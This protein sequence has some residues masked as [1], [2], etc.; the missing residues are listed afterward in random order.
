MDGL[1][2]WTLV[3]LGFIA[4]AGF[5]I[6]S[7]NSVG[8]GEHTS[9]FLAITLALLAWFGVISPSGFAGITFSPV[10]NIT[11]RI[12]IPL[13]GLFGIIYYFDLLKKN[14][15]KEKLELEKGSKYL[16]GAI[17][18]TICARFFLSL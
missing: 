7:I 1:S 9:R 14:W 13:F 18:S 6:V 12:L 5:C 17:A 4:L 3:G 2:L 16:L 11:L 10:E 8:L 15:S